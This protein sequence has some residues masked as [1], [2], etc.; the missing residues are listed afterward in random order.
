MNIRTLQ[1]LKRVQGT[2]NSGSCMSIAMPRAIPPTSVG[3]AMVRRLNFA[4]WKAY[5]LA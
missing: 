4:S 3:N 2:G 5:F 1:F